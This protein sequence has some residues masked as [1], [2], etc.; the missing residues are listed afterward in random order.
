MRDYIYNHNTIRYLSNEVGVKRSI[1][2][3]DGR[4]CGVFQETVLNLEPVLQLVEYPLY[5]L[6]LLYVGHDSDELVLVLLLLNTDPLRH[7]GHSELVAQTCVHCYVREGFHSLRVL[8]PSEV[9]TQHEDVHYKSLFLLIELRYGPLV[10]VV[11]LSVDDFPAVL[12]VLEETFEGL[13]GHLE[14]HGVV[15]LVDH[16]L[17]L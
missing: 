8:P 16:V 4:G 15:G 7:L 17:E 9:Q 5:L 3:N 11:H 6:T 12:Q 13:E 14:D 10:L 2:V 1:P